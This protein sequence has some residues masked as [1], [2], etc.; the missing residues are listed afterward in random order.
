[1]KK[2]LLFTFVFMLLYTPC[3]SAQDST[4]LNHSELLKKFYGEW[5][6]ATKN[7]T[8]QSFSMHPDKNS[9]IQTNYRLIKGKKQTYNVA[10]YNYD[11]NDESFAITNK[12]A[13]SNNAVWMAY[14]IDDLTLR[15]DILEKESG[16]T[17][18]V[19]LFVLNNP[20]TIISSYYNADGD[21]YNE[22]K[23]TRISVK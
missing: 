10:S 21:M 1:M 22:A 8:V 14:F 20:E 9:V 6:Q 18:E 19:R 2:S 23:W 11:P 16:Q 4:K 12:V 5:Q 13:D 15:I 3:I 7:D 17:L